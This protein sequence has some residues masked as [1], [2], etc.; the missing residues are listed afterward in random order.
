MQTLRIMLTIL[1]CNCVQAT[2]NSRMRIVAFGTGTYLLTVGLIPAL[3]PSFDS[4][5][6]VV[7]VARNQ[8]LNNYVF[9][10]KL[11]TCT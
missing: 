1:V 2:Q 5:A 4:K 11:I 8:K 6:R 3:K 7:S 10:A 9:L